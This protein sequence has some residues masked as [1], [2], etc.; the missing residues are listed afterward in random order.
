MNINDV[1]AG[2]IGTVIA[3]ALV[4]CGVS[5]LLSAYAAGIAGSS[6]WIAWAIGG[7]SFAL[8]GLRVAIPS[9]RS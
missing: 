8:I 5:C 4:V 3:A 9:R 6:W 2:L 7:L 1:I